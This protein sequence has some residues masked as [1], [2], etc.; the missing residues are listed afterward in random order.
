M[1]RLALARILGAFIAAVLAA[2]AGAELYKWVDEKGVTNYGSTP[3]ANARNI[4][5]M[6]ESSPRV[7]TVP[8]LKPE[9][10]QAGEKRALEQK[11]DQLERDLEAQRRATADAQAR[12]ATDAQWRE[13]CLADRRIDCDDPS[14]GQPDYDPGVVYPYYPPRPVPP[15]PRPPR[16]MPR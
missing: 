7:S 2:P 11:V 16:P 8:G 9:E 10:I 3:P 6:D 14:R 12:A 15:R 5:K 4:Q 1:H 13:R